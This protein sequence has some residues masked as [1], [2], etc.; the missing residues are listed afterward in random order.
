MS[1]P[2]AYPASKPSAAVKDSPE[3]QAAVAAAVET[4]RSE[5]LSRLE[6]LESRLSEAPAASPFAAELAASIADLSD[7]GLSTKQRRV[8]PDELRRRRE[9]DV[10]MRKLLMDAAKAGIKPRYRVLRACFLDEQLVPPYTR[11][12]SDGPL[13]P[14]EIGWPGVPN[15]SLYP[16]DVTSQAIHEAYLESIGSVIQGP[17]SENKTMWATP[18]GLIIESGSPPLTQARSLESFEHPRIPTPGVTR[19]GPHLSGLT[20]GGSVDP[21]AAHVNVLG[22][23]A[24][25]ARQHAA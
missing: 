2:R 16:L 11:T 13:S 23:V 19:P 25:P 15:E 6:R 5:L 12:R 4:A 9:A 22:S 10:K 8:A 20:I 3:F 24:P 17:D 18:G 21:H 14:T 1:E 7:V